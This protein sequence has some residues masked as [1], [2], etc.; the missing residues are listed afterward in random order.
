[1]RKGSKT[2]QI[3][4]YFKSP[5]DPVLP[6]AFGE[7]TLAYGVAPSRNEYTWHIYV[8]EKFDRGVVMHEAKHRLIKT[9]VHEILHTL[10]IW[11][12]TNKDDIM[13]AMYETGDHK[14]EFA[15][16]T[17]DLLEQLY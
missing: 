6:V 7:N 8:N 13:F 16:S 14:I 11:H 9:L 1:M 2:A 12:S 17:L 5:W 10:N 3:K 4:I 15:K